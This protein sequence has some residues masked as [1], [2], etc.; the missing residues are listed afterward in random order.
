MSAENLSSDLAA[1]LAYWDRK[2]DG[3]CMPARRDL[4]PLL[5]IPRLLPWVMLADVLRDPLD[6]RYRL[7]GTGVV[8]RSRRD[9][10]GRRF[11]EMP[12]AGPDSRIWQDRVTVVET[13][14][15]KLSDPPYIG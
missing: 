5:E 15:P 7:I 3:R 9:F 12:Q 4:D 1:A 11:S 6:F 14:A 10:S 8:N 13:R 2:R